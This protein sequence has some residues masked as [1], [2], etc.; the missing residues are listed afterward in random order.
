MKPDII[1]LMRG[2]RT[3]VAVFVLFMAFTLFLPGPIFAAKDETLD[4]IMNGFDDKKPDASVDTVGDTMDDVLE[5]FEDEPKEDEKNPTDVDILEG[6][7]DDSKKTKPELPKDEIKP[8]IFSLNGD[9]KLGA[10]YNFAHD[11][12]Q[13]NET[14]WRGLSRLR[15]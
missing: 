6:F 7:D 13:G 12:P 3:I 4:E 14:D 8:S 1:N 5:G 11:K 15:T 9:V 10:S 2:N